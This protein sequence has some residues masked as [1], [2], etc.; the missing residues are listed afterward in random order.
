MC[1]V[2]C[3]VF[4]AKY[5]SKDEVSKKRIIEVGSYDVNGTIRP[6]VES[7]EPA[8]YLGV[9]LE[10]GPGVDL[11]CNAENLLEI[12][13]KES[14]DIVISTELIEHVRDWRKVISNLKSICKTDGLILITTR[15]YGFG[16]HAYP[17]DFWR[18]ELE[19]IQNIFSDCEILALE[20]DCQAPGVFLKARKPITFHEN[21]LSSFNLYSVVV[22]KRVNKIT[23]KDFQT[24]YF[25]QLILKD[26]L[27]NFL[28]KVMCSF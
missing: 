19:D 27:R 23:D 6:I 13:K 2:S 25:N 7:W 1:L 18:Y 9:D 28:F 24:F 12:F 8:E 26:K 17:H 14:F 5:L 16:Y 11:T 21:D 4:G 15:S 10:E 22:N 20:K 3:V